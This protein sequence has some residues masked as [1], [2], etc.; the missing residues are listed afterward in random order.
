MKR[1]P[2]A[3]P[4][5]LV[6]ISE[7]ARTIGINKSTLSRQVESGA[8]RSHDGKVVLAQVVED[9]KS[10][11]NLSR[12]GAGRPSP[13]AG[14]TGRAASSPVPLHQPTQRPP[15]PDATPAASDAAEGDL[16]QLL[17]SGAML[18]F[19]AAH[20][21]KE[22]HLARQ[23]AADFEKDIGRLADREAANKL[24]FDQGRV[25]RDA[26]LAARVLR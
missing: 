3:T 12:R 22:N 21:V 24:F 17:A 20:R 15:C 6:S 8:V 11:V 19:A 4:F 13:R 16:E 23:R 18:L 10:N 25:L 7:V 14:R 1:S 2:D 26:W 5:E 9:R